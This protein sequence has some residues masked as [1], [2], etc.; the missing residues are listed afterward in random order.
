MKI[1]R[2]PPPGHSAAPQSSAHPP[3]PAY[4]TPPHSQAHSPSPPSCRYHG[5]AASILRLPADGVVRPISRIPMPQHR[6]LAVLP[7]NDSPPLHARSHWSTPHDA[8]A[9]AQRRVGQ[10]KP[11]SPPRFFFFQSPSSIFNINQRLRLSADAGAWAKSSAVRSLLKPLQRRLLR[12]IYAPQRR[13]YKPRQSH[14]KAHTAAP[15]DRSPPVP[16]AQRIHHPGW[17]SNPPH[18][19]Q[20]EPSPEQCVDVHAPH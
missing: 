18:S 19:R 20:S 9:V 12:R 5:P 11:R 3:P 13:L 4:E 10:K 1:L 7:G 17:S 8:F 2:I 6:A 14:S 16:V 15:P